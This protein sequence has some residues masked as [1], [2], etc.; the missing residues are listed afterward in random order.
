MPEPWTKSD[1]SLEPLQPR[2]LS[3][4]VYYRLRE[5]ILT[6]TI[7]SG[8]RLLESEIARLMGTSQAPVREAI[9][10]L[11]ND[12]LVVKHLRNSAVVAETT[13][14]DYH[15]LFQIRALIERLAARRV[16]G[17]IRPEQCGQLEELIERMRAAAEA[18]NLHTLAINDMEFHRLLCEWSGNPT[19][20]RAW[21]PLSAQVLR[22]LTQYEIQDYETPLEIANEHQALIAALCSHDVDR[23]EATWG[24]HILSSFRHLDSLRAEQDA[25]AAM[26]DS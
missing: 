14:Q 15:E 20:L 10:R 11:V 23:A 21:M 19:L 4:Q 7:P 13:L 26:P 9:Q 8:E 12:G 1:L 24:E 18:H 6:G 25:S 2:S 16:A 22:F 3:D 5:G 17:T